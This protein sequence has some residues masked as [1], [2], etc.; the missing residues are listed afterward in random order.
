MIISLVEKNSSTKTTKKDLA[1]GGQAIIEGVLM[2]SEDTL[3][4]AI[5]KPNDEIVVE[6]EAFRPFTKRYKF[7]NFPII[8][9]FINLL[10]MMYVGTKKLMYSASIAL[11]EETQEK[12]SRKELLLTLM[13]SL[14]ISI[15]F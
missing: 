15:L 1:I 11:E 12:I 5:R 8:R 6:K 3:A 4:T 2:R 14:S 7:L 9:G 13:F 10:E